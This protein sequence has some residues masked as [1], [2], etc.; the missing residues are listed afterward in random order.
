MD[1]RE[2]IKIINQNEEAKQFWKKFLNKDILDELLKYPELLSM[3]DVKRAKIAKEEKEF[4]LKCIFSVSTENGIKFE[5]EE[6]VFDSFY[7]KLGQYIKIVLKQKL[8]ASLT[9]NMIDSLVKQIVQRVFWIPFRCLIADMHEKK[10]A[11]QLNGHSSAEEY[12]DY[13]S[14]Y[15]LNERECGEF[16]KKY[17]VMT[18]LLIR[19]IGDYI[20][21]VNEIFHHFY[22]DRETISKEFHIEQNA[23]KITKISFNQDE[24]HFPER[25]VARVRLKGGQKIYYKPHSTT[26]YLWLISLTASKELSILLLKLLKCMEQSVYRLIHL[27]LRVRYRD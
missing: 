2:L 4:F 6:R 15:L 1:I 23:M 17:P 9:E 22:Q 24:E 8:I 14:K 18:D 21:Y 26:I 20:N 10:D 12:D 25:M 5:K 16:L 3:Q 13:V 19:K 27:G 7:E 11:G